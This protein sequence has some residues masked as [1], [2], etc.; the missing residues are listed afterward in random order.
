MRWVKSIATRDVRLP[1]GCG[2]GSDAINN[3]SLDSCAVTLLRV[4][5]GH[6]GTRLAFTLGAGNQLVYGPTRFNAPARRQSE[7]GNPG[8]LPSW[9]SAGHAVGFCIAA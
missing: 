8:R 7:R 1:I 2:H 5:W 6:S 4:D 9:K 3:D